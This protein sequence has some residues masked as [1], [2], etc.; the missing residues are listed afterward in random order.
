MKSLCRVQLYDSMD[1]NLS[2]SW[3]FPGKSTGVLPFPYP[4]NF[5][6]DPGNKPGSPTLQADTL[7][8]EPPGKLWFLYFNKNNVLKGEIFIEH[9]DHEADNLILFMFY[10]ETK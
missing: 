5:F 6:P 2:S 4:R 8:S 3:D 9:L 1:C 7:P 10:L